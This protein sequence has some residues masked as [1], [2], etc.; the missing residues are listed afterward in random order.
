MVLPCA[1]SRPDPSRP[2]P[3]LVGK[4]GTSRREC[5][6]RKVHR[7][8]VRLG[9]KV[10]NNYEQDVTT[11][12]RRVVQLL[13]LCTETVANHQTQNVVGERHGSNRAVGRG[14]PS[15]RKR[16]PTNK[17]KEVVGSYGGGGGGRKAQG[18]MRPVQSLDLNV[19]D[20]GFFA[21]LGKLFSALHKVAAG[22]NMLLFGEYDRETLDSLRRSL[23]RGYNQ[24]LLFFGMERLRG[25]TEHP[26]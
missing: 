20:L 18:V 9:A 7:T 8:V 6:P 1:A 13:L 21:S 12:R 2:V 10:G 24:L 14:D 16:D 15:L 17:L 5:V 26:D 25:T 3:K 23:L 22:I 19:N 4:I 11:Y